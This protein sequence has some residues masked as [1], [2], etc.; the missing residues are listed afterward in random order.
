MLKEG[1]I[2]KWRVL[3][4]DFEFLSEVRITHCCFPWKA[5]GLQ[6]HGFRDTS[7]PAYA[8]DLYLHSV[9]TVGRILDRAET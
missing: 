3:L 1:L 2:R 6:I 4:D 8:A 7:N 5:V 9:Y